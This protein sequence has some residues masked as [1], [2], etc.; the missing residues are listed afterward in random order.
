MLAELASIT[1]NENC[2]EI[3]PLNITEKKTEEKN[4]NKTETE[5]N[6]YKKPLFFEMKKK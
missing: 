1:T 4:R 5:S 3:V 2:V 6:P